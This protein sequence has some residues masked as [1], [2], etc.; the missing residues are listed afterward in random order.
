MQE[1]AQVLVGGGV[2]SFGDERDNGYWVEPTLW[3]GLAH[4]SRTAREEVFGPCAALIPF[5]DEEEV[6]SL[7]N[8]TDYGLSATLFTRDLS[9]ALRVT[10]RLEAGVIWVNEW[11][12]RDLRTAFGGAEQS[13]I[14][15]EGGLH[16]L[17]FYTEVSNICIKI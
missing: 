3:K 9:R 7:A 13:G 12:L 10:P 1:G 5:A 4:D 17:E 14:G 8:D 11:F 2:P 16:G 15:R 6:V